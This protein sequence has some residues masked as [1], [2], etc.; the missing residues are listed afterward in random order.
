VDLVYSN[1]ISAAVIFARLLD[2]AAESSVIDWGPRILPAVCTEG[3][4]SRCGHLGPW[5]VLE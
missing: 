3:P 1:G 4:T 5:T 2:V